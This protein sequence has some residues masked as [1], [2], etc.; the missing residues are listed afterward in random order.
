MQNNTHIP[1]VWLVIV[2]RL[3]P[4]TEESV[5]ISTQ[6]YAERESAY[7]CKTQLEQIWD[8]KWEYVKVMRRHVKYGVHTPIPARAIALAKH[9]TSN[10]G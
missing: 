4:T 5:T 3:N 10:H 2:G 9:S 1:V 6:V 8:G 7:A